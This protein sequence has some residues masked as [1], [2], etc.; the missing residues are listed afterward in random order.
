[1]GDFQHVKNTSPHTSITYPSLLMWHWYF[2]AW[3]AGLW[4]ARYF[5]PSLVLLGSIIF[6]YTLTRHISQQLPERNLSLSQGSVRLG[7]L[8]VLFF[9]GIQVGSATIPARPYDIRTPDTLPPVVLKKKPVQVTGRIREVITSPDRR[10]KFILTDATYSV[11]ESTH[12]VT[13]DIVW[14]WANRKD[15]WNKQ[16]AA[17]PPEMSPTSAKK[18]TLD[19]GTRIQRLRPM[20]G[21]TVSLKAKLLPIVGFRNK[22]L[23]NSQEY[24]QN[25]GVFWRMWTWGDKAIPVRSGDISLLTE[26][27]ETMRFTVSNQLEEL[28]HTD[29]GKKLASTLGVTPFRDAVRFIP[30]LVFGDRYDIPNRRYSQLSRASLSHS[31]ALSGMH[32]AIVA[33][34]VSLLLSICIRR[35]HIYE[36]ISRPKLLALAILP[37]AALYV[38]IGGGSPSL[39]RAFI[40]L[41]CWCTL[42][43]FNRPQ[44]FMDGL[45]WALAI[46]TIAD[47]LIIFDLRLQLSALAI[48]AIIIAM[49]LVA[50]AKAY[51]LPEKKTRL[52]RLKRAAFD[53][54]LL[55]IAIQLVL[56]PVTIWNFNELSL[57]NILNIIW[58]P[59]L[60]M[61]IMP[62]MLSGLIV[63]CASLAFPVLT[64]IA[65]TIFATAAAPIATL[66][67]FLDDMDNAGFLAPII[68]QRPDWLGIVAWYGTILSALVWWQIEGRSAVPEMFTSLYEGAPTW[69]SKLFTAAGL[70]L[71][72]DD[73][74]NQPSTQRPSDNTRQDTPATHQN[75]L[76]STP[77]PQ[78][79]L[80]HWMARLALT[81]F[82]LL[83]F[84][85]EIQQAYSPETR[86]K[87][88]ILDVGQGQALLLTFPNGKRMLVDGGG[89]SS[90]SFDIGR[91]IIV[92][93]ITR[94]HDDSLHWVLS[95]HPDTDHIRGLFHPLAYA[96]VQGYYATAAIPH[97]WNKKQLAN[98][99]KKSG[100]KKTVLAAGDTLTISE[101]LELEVLHPSQ[102]SFLEGNNR[103]LVLRLVEHVGNTR[104]GLVLLTGD[105][106]LK[107]IEE[108]L[109]SN[110][111]LSAE[112]LILPHHGSASSYSPELY[113]AVSPKLAIASCGFMNKYNFPSTLVMDELHRRGIQTLTTAKHGEVELLLE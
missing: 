109:R 87:L 6:F 68:M 89:F 111:D 36:L 5:I 2:L 97:G 1:M 17:K 62:L 92:P 70:P 13:G 84:V 64:P 30:A 11:D 72:G 101:N 65:E 40:M 46:M 94:Q 44:V 78:S 55:S 75:W 42:L 93:S 99:L 14:T 4:G 112:V 79:R 102:D 91:A 58:L 57:W 63:A 105:I 34:S 10:I 96:D 90:R 74:E 29:L 21:E 47:P 54:F 61:I 23:W 19:K 18:G 71:V 59:L 48:V 24:W 88:N 31:F 100:I 82:I 25:K 81:S 28:I 33:L 43:L 15:A 76:I 37:A 22:S 49:P 7:L 95:T 60:G 51:L 12:R 50:S 85:P 77:V 73:I 32:L 103:S 16:Q 69:E 45:F 53:I 113:D 26:W 8:C 110:V 56:Y 67:A 107:G 108:L 39:M 98:S 86:T 52:Q 106:E 3:L 35:A 38:W 20:V 104:K 27:R 66:F 41:C 83:A 80:A 9:I